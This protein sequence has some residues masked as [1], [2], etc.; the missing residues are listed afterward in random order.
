[1]ASYGECFAECFGDLLNDIGWW[2]LALLIACLVAAALGG[3]L[4][5]GIG[6]AAA[7]VVVLKCLGAALG[8]TALGA[9]THCLLACL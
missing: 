5:A 3:I 6:A 9:L 4:T 8:G 1:M 2:T 7:G